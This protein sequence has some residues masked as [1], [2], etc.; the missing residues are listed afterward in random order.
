MRDEMIACGCKTT[1]A[2]IGLPEREEFLLTSMRYAPYAR[3][4]LTF[5][6]YLAAQD[7]I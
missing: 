6:K 7:L 5:L 3:N 4:R 1:L 2:E